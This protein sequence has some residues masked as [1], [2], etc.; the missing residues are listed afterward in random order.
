MNSHVAKRFLPPPEYCLGKVCYNKRDAQAT[1]NWRYKKD[2]IELR[3]YECHLGDHWHLT[4][5][6]EDFY[7]GSR[8]LKKHK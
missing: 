4:S 1:K 6:L 3:I 8:K 7:P 2:H 5:R